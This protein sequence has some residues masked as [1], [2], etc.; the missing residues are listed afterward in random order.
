LCYITS[1]QVKLT[2]D[3]EVYNLNS[4]D[5]IYFDSSLEHHIA[6]TETA[7]I[8]IIHIPNNLDTNSAKLM[9]IAS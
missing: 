4:D 5:T 6:A 2:I 9:T 7:K 1:G 3:D 8:T